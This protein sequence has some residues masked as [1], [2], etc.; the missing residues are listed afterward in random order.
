MKVNTPNPIVQRIARSRSAPDTS[1]T[2]L[3]I[4]ANAP[5]IHEATLAVLHSSVANVT[6]FSPCF[7]RLKFQFVV[8][9]HASA[10]LVVVPFKAASATN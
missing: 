1:A 4:V 5:P 8:L 9:A 7:V 10:T 3:I 6:L 2:M